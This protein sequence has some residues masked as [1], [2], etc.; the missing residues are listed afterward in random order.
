MIG[1]ANNLTKSTL[2]IPTR[3][4]LA[5]SY[6]YRATIVITI[7]GNFRYISKIVSCVYRR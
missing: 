3:H 5:M 2:A 1:L 4:D 6:T 7:A